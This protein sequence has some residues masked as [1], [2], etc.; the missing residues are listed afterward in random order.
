M[1]NVT[2]F[3]LRGHVNSVEKNAGVVLSNWQ[4]GMLGVGECGVVNMVGD[5]AHNEVRGTYVVLDKLWECLSE[6]QLGPANHISSQII[7]IHSSK[8]HGRCTLDYARELGQE[9]RAIRPCTYVIAVHGF[10]SNIF[11][12]FFVEPFPFAWLLRYGGGGI[13]VGCHPVRLEEVVA[14]KYCLPCYI[15]VLFFVQ[16]T[17]SWM[18]AITCVGNWP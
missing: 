5:W 10:H 2:W 12:F 16:L 15:G 1:Y 8:S 4:W 14:K 18:G 3:S 13:R 7:L 11:S 9:A 6:V 17:S